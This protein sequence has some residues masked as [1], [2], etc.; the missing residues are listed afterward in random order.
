MLSLVGAWLGVRRVEGLEVHK[1]LVGCGEQAR[2]FSS[3]LLRVGLWSTSFDEDSPLRLNALFQWASRRRLV[4]TGALN[5]Q[6]RTI[7]QLRYLVADDSLRG[8]EEQA[9]SHR[10]ARHRCSN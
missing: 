1:L 5:Q 8:G 6:S 7:P 9:R 10:S 3:G 4:G 2:E